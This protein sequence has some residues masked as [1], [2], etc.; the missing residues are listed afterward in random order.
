MIQEEDDTTVARRT[1]LHPAEAEGAV[2]SLLVLSGPSMGRAY[3]LSKGKLLIGRGDDVDLQINDENVSRHHAKVIRLA[4]DVY[5]IKDLGSK[6]GTFVNQVPVET[7]PLSE[8]DQVQIGDVSLK[9][10][11]EDAIEANL[12]KRLFD[13]AMK[14]PLTNAYNRRAFDEQLVRALAFARRHEQPVSIVL[15][16]VDY[17]KKVNDGHGHPAGDAVL[18]QLASIVART[19]RTEDFFARTGGEEFAVVC[20]GNREPQ[21][22]VLAERLLALVRG[23]E[24]RL[25]DGT[26]LQLTMSAGVAEFSPHS[27]AQPEDV[28]ARADQSLYRAKCGGRD[29]VCVSQV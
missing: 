5:I 6:N 15:M 4:N 7:H 19:L 20:T 27:E 12:R 25:P 3:A 23:S 26:A 18:Q 22:V 13:A 29:R 21:A 28:I 14:D 8:G 11:V 9:F 24:F 16:D 17:F 10:A 2:P 1:T